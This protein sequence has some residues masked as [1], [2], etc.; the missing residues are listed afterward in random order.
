MCKRFTE[1]QIKKAKRWPTGRLQSVQHRWDIPALTWPCFGRTATRGGIPG[2]NSR[3]LGLPMN[4]LFLV[5]AH[6][7]RA[8]RGLKFGRRDYRVVHVTRGALI[9]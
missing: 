9:G 5:S 3:W 6:V 8:S 4:G 7:K 1:S 2:I